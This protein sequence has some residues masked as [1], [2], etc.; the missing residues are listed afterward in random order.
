M[1]TVVRLMGIERR[2]YESEGKQ[3]MYCGLHVAHVPGCNEEVEGSYCENMSCP[4]DV[5][6]RKLKIGNLYELEY[7]IYNTKNGKG[8]RLVGLLPVEG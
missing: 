6:D 8:A 7:M 4:R 2:Q 5:D 1:A 3:R